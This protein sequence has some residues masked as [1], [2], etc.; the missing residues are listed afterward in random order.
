MV[1]PSAWSKD[2]VRGWLVWTSRQCNLGPLPL[3]HFDIEGASLVA[4]T[5][6]EFRMAAPQGNQSRLNEFQ[7]KS[8][9][10]K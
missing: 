8:V 5:E 1:D 6:E 4:L 3:E 9:N 7:S 2:D 10:E